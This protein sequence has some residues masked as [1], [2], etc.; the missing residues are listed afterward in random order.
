MEA[1]RRGPLTSSSS[2]S[3]SSV[4]SSNSEESGSS[5]ADSGFAKP[6][7]SDTEVDFTP[8]A[9]SLE[10]TEEFGRRVTGLSGWARWQVRKL[11]AVLTRMR[12]NLPPSARIDA[13]RRLGWRLGP[14]VEACRV[15]AERSGPE[16]TQV[17]EG[18]DQIRKFLE[19]WQQKYKESEERYRAER[20]EAFRSDDEVRRAEVQLA[21]ERTA[22][23][24]KRTKMI[25]QR[26]P[27]ITAR[28]GILWS[29]VT[30]SS[31]PVPSEIR[32]TSTGTEMTAEE[33]V[34]TAETHLRYAEGHLQPTEEHMADAEVHLKLVK[35]HLAAL[36]AMEPLETEPCETAAMP[37][38]EPTSNEAGTDRKET[39]PEESRDPTP[40]SRA[41][42]VER[43]SGS[44]GEMLRPG[45]GEHWT[46]P[47]SECQDSAVHPLDECEKFKNLSVPQREK[48]VKEWNRCECCL[49][50]CRD[51]KTGSR[52]YRRIGFRWHH[53]LRLVPQAEANQAGSRRRQQQRP[54]RKTAKGDQNT[55]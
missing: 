6:S 41:G 42:L 20:D 31:R 13:V 14:G 46:C 45:A 3:D 18:G 40:R 7:S 36:V 29:E 33:H 37:P 39:V 54:R 34:A 19:E 5:S 47:V 44:D 17:P 32:L 38:V 12:K 55:P 53:L 4:V 23:L 28:L 50:D 35:A 30:G 49:T 1:R 8:S 16:P 22:E 27:I 51:R 9:P 48:G 15:I 24:E 21:A 11:L 52:C 2:D 25:E 10:E 26:L 43:G